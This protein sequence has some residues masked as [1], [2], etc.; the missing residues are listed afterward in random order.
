M[1][2]IIFTEDVKNL[3][4]ISED[5]LYDP[6]EFQPGNNFLN[7]YPSQI[8]LDAS[9]PSNKQVVGVRGSEI[10]QDSYSKVEIGKRVFA[11]T[12]KMSGQEL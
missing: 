4:P 6:S 7:F 11:T 12:M 8:R 10:F 5:A 3:Q 1:E 2:S 9:D